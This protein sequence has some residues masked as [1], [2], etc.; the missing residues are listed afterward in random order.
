MNAHEPHQ[1]I[2]LDAALAAIGER[3]EERIDRLVARRRGRVRALVATLAVATVA[4]GAATAAALTW[5]P[6]VAPDAG[7]A[8]QRQLACVPDD[9]PDA[10]ALFTAR[11][12]I[13]VDDSDRWDPAALCEAAAARLAAQP[14]LTSASP[15]RLLATAVEMYRST[16]P[17]AV[18]DG[19]S[20]PPP[21][22][23]ARAA[24]FLVETQLGADASEAWALCGSAG[25][26]TVLMVSP[27]ASA[28]PASV[29]TGCVALEAGG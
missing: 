3:V 14:S 9:E 23:E 29:P 1:G 11:F 28:R 6:D 15:S 4:G 26:V 19:E 20:A 7:E 8:V 21:R 10:A 16:S 12:R 22:V 18:I 13:A 25:D 24:T 5:G 27:S 2:Y 17:A